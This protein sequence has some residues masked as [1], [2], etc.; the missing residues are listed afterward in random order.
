MVG[1]EITYSALIT[2]FLPMKFESNRTIPFKY[3]TVTF[4][5]KKGLCAGFC[6]TVET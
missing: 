3:G 2:K 1:H 6:K 5:C 4:D